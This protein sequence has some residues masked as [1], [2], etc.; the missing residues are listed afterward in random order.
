VSATLPPSLAGLE[1]LARNVYWCWDPEG[2]EL[3]EELAPRRWDASQHNPVQLLRMVYPEDLEERAQDE[4]YLQKIQ[5]VLARFDAYVAQEPR[6]I[7]LE[8]GG[9]LSAR[10]RWPTSARS[11][12][13]TS[14]SRSTRAVSACS[15]ATTS[16]PPATCACRWSAWDSSIARATWCRR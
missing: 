2:R 14:R 15:P 4:H 6:S 11:S 12:A 8:G 3:F 7:P 1:R 10:G 9:A 16:R 5:R 13:C